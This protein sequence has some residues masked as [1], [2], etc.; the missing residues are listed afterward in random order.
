VTLEQRRQLAGD[1]RARLDHVRESAWRA[2][3]TATSVSLQLSALESARRAEVTY[4]NA[5]LR[6]GLVGPVA[7]PTSTEHQ[8]V[9]PAEPLP[10]PPEF[11]DRVAQ[12]IIEA[13]LPPLEEPIP[14]SEILGECG[15]G[16]GA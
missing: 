11:A 3:A 15:S 16:T 5:L 2:L 13:S 10:W 14:E 9:K 12:A 6:L 4:L 7:T 8:F 1:I